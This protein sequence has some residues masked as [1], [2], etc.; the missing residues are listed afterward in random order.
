MPAGGLDLPV[1][2]L[3]LQ[4]IN[5]K[6]ELNS[7]Q[8]AQTGRL[9]RAGAP[10]AASGHRGEIGGVVVVEAYVPESL[11]AKMEGIGRQYEEYKQ[12][13]AMK[14]PIKAGAYLFVAVVTVL[15]LFG[16][17]WF[18][19]YVRARYYGADSAVG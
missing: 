19:F 2:Q 1:S 15:I 14:N 8:E 4:V 11:L 16:A 5:G 7:V 17:T 18:G 3:V 6:Q 9:V 13:K 10:V 12:I